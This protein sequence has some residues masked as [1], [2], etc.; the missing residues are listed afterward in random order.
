MRHLARAGGSGVLN[1]CTGRGTSVLELAHTL[2][3]LDGW[4][5]RLQYAPPRPGD[6]ARSVGDPAAAI[7][8]LGVRAATP[9]A[10]GLAT[11]LAW[12]QPA[13]A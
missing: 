12:L 9:L 10:E 3:R 6:I 13:A 2:A 8:T 5:P 7:A 11:T 4:A 1:V